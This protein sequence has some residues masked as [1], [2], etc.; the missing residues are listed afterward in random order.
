[1]FGSISKAI[2]IMSKGVCAKLK[3]HHLSCAFIMHM[4]IGNISQTK[5][6]FVKNRQHLLLLLPSSCS[7]LELHQI[8]GREN[9]HKEDNFT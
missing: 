2:R 6:T 5:H 4:Y 7:S 8:H 9:V 1:M 3:P